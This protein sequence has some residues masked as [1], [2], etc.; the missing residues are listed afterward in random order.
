M[1][2]IW[3]LLC[4]V[5][6]WRMVIWL[7]RNVFN[8]NRYNNRNKGEQSMEMMMVY[9]VIGVVLYVLGTVGWSF[10]SL[11]YTWFNCKLEENQW[12]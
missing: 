5:I 7:D 2:I 3:T 8:K 1:D 6:G 10:L 4:I 12:K 9:I 11:V